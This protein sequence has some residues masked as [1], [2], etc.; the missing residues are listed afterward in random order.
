MASVSHLH[1]CHYGSWSS[2][3][4]FHYSLPGY[5]KMCKD[6]LGYKVQK[7][8]ANSGSAFLIEKKLIGVFYRVYQI[9]DVYA[10]SWIAAGTSEGSGILKNAAS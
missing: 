3:R 9:G 2:G 10:R 4:V 8:R 7:G 6:D 5:L 1:V